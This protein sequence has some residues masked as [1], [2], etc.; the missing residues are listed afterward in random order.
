MTMWHACRAPSTLLAVYKI[1][2]PNHGSRSAVVIL[3]SGPDTDVV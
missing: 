1:A 3:V 2:N